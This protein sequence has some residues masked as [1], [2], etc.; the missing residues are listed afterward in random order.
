MIRD[1][2]GN[3]MAP[4]YNQVHYTPYGRDDWLYDVLANDSSAPLVAK[5]LQAK[6]D[7]D[8][9]DAETK[10]AT[11]YSGIGVTGFCFNSFNDIA[12][13]WRHLARSF[14][15][16]TLLNDFIASPAEKQ[17]LEKAGV[18]LPNLMNFLVWRRSAMKMSLLLGI[19]ML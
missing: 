17:Y 13:M 15:Q 3:P 19:L 11:T 12:M 4:Y 2:W 10:G 16:E 14:E 1:Q 5:E 18:E 9:Q 7:K 8:A 6:M